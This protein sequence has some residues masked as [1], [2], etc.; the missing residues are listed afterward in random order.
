MIELLEGRGKLVLGKYSGG[1]YISDPHDIYFA[2]SESS[3]YYDGLVLLNVSN[4]GRK[5]VIELDSG[6][7]LI[8]ELEP[9]IV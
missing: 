6:G 7:C 3:G 9:D 2:I 4:P 1:V 5:G 8:I